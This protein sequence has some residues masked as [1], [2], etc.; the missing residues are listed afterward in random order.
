M[1][2]TATVKD[3]IINLAKVV[4]KKKGGVR[5]CMIYYMYYAR[6]Y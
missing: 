2:Q 5:I 1:S 3:A 6:Y 4:N